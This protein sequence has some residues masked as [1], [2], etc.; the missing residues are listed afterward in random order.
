MP[1]TAQLDI[2]GVTFDSHSFPSHNAKGKEETRVTVM[3][4][5][6][7]HP[8]IAKESP[9]QAEGRALAALKNCL[10]I[11]QTPKAVKTALATNAIPQYQL[12]HDAKIGR[13]HDLASRYTA[14]R[15]TLLGTT[16]HGVS[17]NDCISHATGAGM[18]LLMANNA[19]TRSGPVSQYVKGV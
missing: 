4:G 17:V 7:R 13:L 9:E 1:T 10:G 11:T 19:S 12:N 8:H 3:M 14:G 6:G 15:L 16:V 18:K 2:L 5:G